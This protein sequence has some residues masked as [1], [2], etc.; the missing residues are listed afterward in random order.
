MIRKLNADLKSLAKLHDAEICREENTQLF[1]RL[2][3]ISHWNSFAADLIR[4]SKTRPLSERQIDAAWEMLTK[5]SVREAEK[6]QERAEAQKAAEAASQSLGGNSPA[7]ELPRL[8]ETFLSA[9]ASLKW[10][11]LRLT[12]SAD[13][14]VVLSLCGPNSRTPGHINVTDGGSYGSNIY[15]GRISPEGRAE[16]RTTATP[17]VWA[18]LAAYN[19]DPLAEGKVQGLRTGRCM[20]CG[21]ELTNPESVELGIGPICR[22][23]WGY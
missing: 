5:I 16:L 23:N 11:K 13:R 12:T 4:Q 2:E 10:P 17:D 19:A 21:R 14:S 7:S 8:A 18:V 6:A 3:E 9:A 1:I 20:C 15:Y 22:D